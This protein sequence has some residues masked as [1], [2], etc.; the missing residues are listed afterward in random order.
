[1]TFER[2]SINSGNQI[3]KSPEHPLC[4]RGDGGISTDD[5]TISNVR[6]YQIGCPRI[7]K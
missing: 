6:K 3:N 4:K 2:T 1:M 7:K 5:V